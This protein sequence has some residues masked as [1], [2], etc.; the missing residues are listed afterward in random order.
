LPPDIPLFITEVNIAWATGESFVDIFGALWLA[1]YVGAFLTAG[2]DG[3]Y[4]FHYLPSAVHGGCNQSYGTFGM[5]TVDSNYQI[6]QPTSQ[7][8]ASQMLTQEWVQ[9]GDGDHRIFP[10]T[11]DILDPAGHVLVTAYAVHRPDGQWSLL[12]INKD[13]HNAH[14]VRIVFHGREAGTDRTFTGSTTMITFGSAQYQW[15]AN[16]RDG[17][18]NPDGP[19]ARST[20][21]AGGDTVFELPGASVSVIRGTLAIVG[22]QGGR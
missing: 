18:A 9:P 22:A 8:F 15:R 13:Q 6:L 3:L 2:G 10:V 17:V 5:F 12:V 20:V 11:S 1:D 14:P 19:P 21:A 16:G 4:Y 7:F